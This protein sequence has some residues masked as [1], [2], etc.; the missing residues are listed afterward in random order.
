[1]Q[2]YAEIMSRKPDKNTMNKSS[3]SGFLGGCT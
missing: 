1:M 3:L 2:T